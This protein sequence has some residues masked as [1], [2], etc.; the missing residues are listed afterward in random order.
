M[1]MYPF[2]C[3]DQHESLVYASFAEAPKPGTKGR[4]ECGKVSRRVI[5]GIAQYGQTKFG[6][7]FRNQELALGQ[8]F[9]SVQEID[10]YCK[11]NNLVHIGN[12]TREIKDIRK[13]R[14]EN[15]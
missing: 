12:S 2:V 1:P 11:K 9:N 15:E 5:S 13:R 3:V 8:K 7:Q 14:Q 6:G 4:C 10:A